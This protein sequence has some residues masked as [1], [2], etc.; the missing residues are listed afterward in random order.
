MSA[1]SPMLN[2]GHWKWKNK[3]S[4]DAYEEFQLTENLQEES[5]G[6]QLEKSNG[7]DRRVWCDGQAGDVDKGAVLQQL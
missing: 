7:E 1:F 6:L 2:A 5:S 3:N 4:G